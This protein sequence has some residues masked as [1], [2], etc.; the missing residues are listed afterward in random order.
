MAAQEQSEDLLAYE[1]LK[2]VPTSRT[3]ARG[4]RKLGSLDILTACEEEMCMTTCPTVSAT[5]C[6]MTNTQASSFDFPHME[7]SHPLPKG[8]NPS[9]PRILLRVQDLRTHGISLQMV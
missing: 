2:R 3:R 6:P 1:S 5:V 7:L 9:R 4:A 8:E